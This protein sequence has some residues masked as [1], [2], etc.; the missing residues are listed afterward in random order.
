MA[1]VIQGWRPQ[2]DSNPC[3]GLERA[4]SWASGR[5]GRSGATRR[6]GRTRH[7]STCHPR[8]C[9]GTSAPHPHLASPE[10][11]AV[12][13]RQRSRGRQ[14]ARQSD[15]RLLDVAPVT[16]QDPETPIKDQQGHHTDGKGEQI[17]HADSVGCSVRGRMLSRRCCGPGEAPDGASDGADTS[18]PSRAECE[19]G[20]MYACRSPKRQRDEERFAC[21]EQMPASAYTR[22]SSTRPAGE[23]ITPIA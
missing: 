1:V 21:I 5:W 4:T 9:P 3:F 8:T 15:P 16:R 7:F 22:S 6:A 14:V 11:V 20:R 19:L 10:P 13:S 2:R 12:S 18:L 17:T 23:P